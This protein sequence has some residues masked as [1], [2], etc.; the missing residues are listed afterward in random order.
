[1]E[2]HFYERSLDIPADIP[3]C[4]CWKRTEE[5]I[6]NSES[7]IVTTQMGLLSTELLKKGYRVFVHPTREDK[8]EIRLGENECTDKEIRVAHNLFKMWEAG[9]F[10]VPKN[11]KCILSDFDNITKLGK[12]S[13]YTDKVDMWTVFKKYG[14]QFVHIGYYPSVVEDEVQC[15]I[16]AN[17]GNDPDSDVIAAA[18]IDDDGWI[19]SFIVDIDYRGKGYGEKLLQFAINEYGIYRLKVNENNIPAI[20]FYRK[21]GFKSIDLDTSTNEDLFLIMELEDNQNA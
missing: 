19:S 8:Y 16:L 20:N 18:L 10:S 7:Y 9:A 3:Y 12:L 11:Q 13:N 5:A 14:S 4:V 17:D 21:L 1:M 2:I 6:N 15:L